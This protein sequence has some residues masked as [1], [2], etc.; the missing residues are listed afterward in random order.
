[1]TEGDASSADSSWND[2]T[3]DDE[4][5]TAIRKSRTEL[6]KRPEHVVL[7]LEP[8]LPPTVVEWKPYCVEALSL[9]HRDVAFQKA[10]RRTDESEE[11]IFTQKE[12]VSEMLCL[13]NGQTQSSL[14]EMDKRGQLAPKNMTHT[15]SRV[16]EVALL[17]AKHVQQLTDFIA[18]GPVPKT[19]RAFQD[20]LQDFMCEHARYLAKMHRIDKLGILQLRYVLRPQLDRLSIIHSLVLPLIDAGRL[21]Y[22]SV[23]DFLESLLNCLDLCAIQDAHL[24]KS[25]WDACIGTLQPTVHFLDRLLLDGTI[26][27]SC[28]EFFIVRD[29]VHHTFHPKP[30]R[31]RLFSTEVLE[32]VVQGSDAASIL[33]QLPLAASRRSQIRFSQE[34]TACLDDS[35]DFGRAPSERLMDAILIAADRCFISNSNLLMDCVDSDKQLSL[36]LGDIGIIYSAFAL[37]DFAKEFTVAADEEEL[38]FQKS[39][40]RSLETNGLRKDRVGLWSLSLEK[41]ID[42]LTVSPK[43]PWPLNAIITDDLISVLNFAL[44]LL[45]KLLIAR[46]TL[47]RLRFHHRRNDSDAQTSRR[48]HFLLT[49]LLQST[50]AVL[51]IYATHIFHLIKHHAA[52]ICAAQ[53][54]QDA[55]VRA[56]NLTAAL[57]RSVPISKDSQ[58]ILNAA[59]Q[60]CELSAKFA[61]IWT[62]ETVEQHVLDN[63]AVVLTRNR[64]L[65]AMV[66]T[67]SAS[68]GPHL[69]GLYLITTGD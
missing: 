50:N 12:F 49:D 58:L 25:L 62:A 40:E 31:C 14:V 20:T 48:M 38:D 67:K 42:S 29:E 23:Q 39:F 10:R 66:A 17:S 18:F 46:N 21:D 35:R 44:R 53:S 52:I 26:I 5:T 4:N 32:R 36:M 11:C 2:D 43:C 34:F 64:R 61:V 30:V 1:M 47:V 6:Q 16:N 13:L 45:L 15:L 54:Y 60:L 51:G 55:Q 65:L 19:I 3:T 63:L 69:A 22:F 41:G 28:G 7:H 9:H 57:R 27:D 59:L 68:S 37:R 33:R 56:A 24:F 8:V